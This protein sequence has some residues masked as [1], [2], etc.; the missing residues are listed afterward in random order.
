M[1]GRTIL[2]M[3][4]LAVSG[5][6][7]DLTLQPVA[8]DQ[9]GPGAAAGQL[10]NASAQQVTFDFLGSPQT[11]VV[12]S[13][14]TSITVDVRGA[15]GGGNA[16]AP[17]PQ[18]GKGGR[19]QTTLA[20]TPGETLV[21]YVGGRGG[22]LDFSGPNTAG[23]GGFNGGGAGGIDNVDFN[24]AAGGGGGA[25]D[26]RQGGNG[27]TS[28]VVV[29][30][31]GGGAE[32]CS[33]AIGGDG[34]GTTGMSGGTVGG[35]EPGGGGTQSA[36]GAGGTGC[37]GN[38]SSGSVGQG[39]VGGNG[40]RA[41]G[42]GGGGYYGGGGGGGCT[43]GSGGGGGSSYSAGQ[44]TI[45]TQGYQTGAGQV[46]I[47]YEAPSN[48]PPVANAGPDQRIAGA[49][50]VVQF[51][52]R[53]MLD[54][55]ASFD[56]DNDPLSYVWSEGT[57]V[58][59]IGSV[60]DATDALA[61]GSHTVTLTVDDGTV[62]SVDQVLVTVTPLVVFVHG[63][64]GNPT[65]TFG[66]F[67]TL[68]GQD[69]TT[70]SFDYSQ[71]TDCQGIRPPITTVADAFGTF[72]EQTL[73]G[74]G[75]QYSGHIEIVAHSMG[76]LV[77]RAYMAGLTSRRYLSGMF[78]RVVTVGTPNYGAQ[79]L[80]ILALTCGRVPLQPQ[81]ADMA[82]ASAFVVLTD[83]AWGA[84]QPIAPTNVLTLAGVV[85]PS[86]GDYA[87][88]GY[89]ATLTSGASIAGYPP[90]KHSSAIPLPASCELAFVE[91]LPHPV[92]GI[93]HDYLTTG[94]LPPQTPPGL[95]VG[96]A[97]LLFVDSNGNAI[98]LTSQLTL[99]LRRGRLSTS[100]QCGQQR[101]IV[102]DCPAIATVGAAS[103]RNLVLGPW[104]LQRA[105]AKGYRLAAPVTFNVSDGRPVVQR[106]VLVEP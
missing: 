105:T 42:G 92:Y 64:G 73:L 13:N 9:V 99:V 70:L 15:Q 46:V 40:N 95:P 45:H 39:G 53:V 48:Q 43:F 8:S 41:G 102:V 79:H 1:K 56:P 65:G 50:A 3:L 31:G 30:G 51:P 27:L 69:F 101:G 35:S 12:P 16:S 103:L 52:P 82:F 71:L 104:T 98:P 89:S 67:P 38:G 62:S 90:C 96:L 72:V 4:A 26:I 28:R 14:V 2:F 63:I 17:T 58:L 21:I 80:R 86:T 59:G 33:G 81:E 29:A 47:A 19:A 32:C 25:S 10:A 54:G 87:V 18:G 94:Q 61:P 75:P 76:G 37:N 83:R 49:I 106:V 6:C 20:V 74:T 77:V 36:G 11:W 5:A 97:L 24:A 55:S 91:A 7:T 23:P 100:V 34:G 93:V 88:E 78:E 84:A 66:Q 85:P 68:L 44:G 22:D 57:A 60:L